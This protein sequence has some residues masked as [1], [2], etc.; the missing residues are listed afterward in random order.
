MKKKGNVKYCYETLSPILH[1]YACDLL[2]DMLSKKHR[3]L[4]NH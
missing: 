2:A 4:L 3:T 1:K